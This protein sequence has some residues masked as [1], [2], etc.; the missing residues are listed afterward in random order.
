MFKI[1]RESK[2]QEYM[3]VARFRAAALNVGPEGRMY[4][5]PTLF[6]PLFVNLSFYVPFKFLKQTIT[7]S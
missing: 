4:L 1:V 2:V 3:A 6:I 5:T 7:G